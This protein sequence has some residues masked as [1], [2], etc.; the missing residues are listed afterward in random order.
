[1]LTLITIL[2]VFLCFFLIIVI[3]L[4]AGK[5]GDV[6]AA[7]G[8][9]GASSTV[10]GASGAGTLLSRVTTGVAMLFMVTSISLSWFSNADARR[11]SVID[12]SVIEETQPAEST[13]AAGGTEAAPTDATPAAPDA[14]PAPTPT[15]VAPPAAPPAE[16]PGEAP[17]TP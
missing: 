17:A 1:M 5:G 2:H 11:D 13:P 7:F 16:A 14:T 12:G 15:D 3:L 10:F 8:G 9:A 6:G 4:Q